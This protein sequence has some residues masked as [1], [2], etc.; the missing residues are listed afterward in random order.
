M[1]LDKAIYQLHGGC[2]FAEFFINGQTADF[3]FFYF[4]LFR[5]L[6]QAYEL[7]HK[8]ANKRINSANN[9]ACDTRSRP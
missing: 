9:Y 8:W 7:A 6:D 5:S 1:K 4:G 3:R 2:V